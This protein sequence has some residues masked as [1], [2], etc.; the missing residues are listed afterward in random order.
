ML[1]PCLPFKT[2]SSI[3]IAMRKARLIDYYLGAMLRRAREDA[4]MT[5]KTLSEKTGIA[6]ATIAT[7]EQAER[8]MPLSTAIAL[9]AGIRPMS[10][11]LAPMNL[12]VAE[13]EPH[14]STSTTASS[15]NLGLPSEPE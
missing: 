15:A 5:R 6:P 4:N 1:L 14:C 11:W 10:E 7:Y 9:F 2:A 3:T 8:A 12:V 13:D